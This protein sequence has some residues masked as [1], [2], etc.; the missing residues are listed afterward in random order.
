MI[1][2]FIIIG[3]DYH[4]YSPLYVTVDINGICDDE[5]LGFS[6]EN[7]TIYQQGFLFNLLNDINIFGILST[8]LI[9]INDIADNNI[10]WYVHRNIFFDN[11][12]IGASLLFYIYRED[13]GTLLNSFFDDTSNICNDFSLI[14]FGQND[15]DICN[16]NNNRSYLD[17]I[18]STDVI[19]II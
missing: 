13:H 3:Y 7:M 1:Y 17:C 14:F 9:G 19:L 18:P 11:N 4:D 2:I 10:N 12:P 5:I 6:H 8:S 15:Y 16:I